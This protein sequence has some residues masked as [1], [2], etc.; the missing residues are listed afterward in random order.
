MPGGGSARRAVPGGVSSAGAA[1]T[2]SSGRAGAR[3]T[4]ALVSAL[5][6]LLCDPC[7][8]SE[9]KGLKGV[10]GRAG[11][12]RGRPHSP[13]ASA[14][15]RPAQKHVRFRTQDAGALAGL[16]VSPGLLHLAGDTQLVWKSTVQPALLKSPPCAR[17]GSAPIC[18]C[19]WSSSPLAKSLLREPACSLF[20]RDRQT[21]TARRWESH[22]T[23]TVKKPTVPRV[24]RAA[25]HRELRTLLWSSGTTGTAAGKSSISQQS[26]TN[27]RLLTEQLHAY[28]CS[29]RRVQNW[30]GEHC[31]YVKRLHTI[32]M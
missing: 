9:S 8:A 21:L 7:T 5:Q 27:T 18:S 6:S 30:F 24:G 10:R 17:P 31:L 22:Q 2:R 26:R 13:G 12:P 28:L 29:R 23:A 16:T 1:G 25:G 14:R 20:H 3:P 19:R 11:V 4:A 15:T 32:Q